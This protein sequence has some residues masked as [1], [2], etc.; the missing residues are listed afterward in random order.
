MFGIRIVTNWC[1]AWPGIKHITIYLQ[2]KHMNH[3][4]NVAADNQRWHKTIFNLMTLM[5]Q[6]M[7]WCD[8]LRC[9]VIKH[10]WRKTDTKSARWTL[11]PLPCLISNN[12][13]HKDSYLQPQV[14]TCLLVF[15]LAGCCW[16]L[17]AVGALPLAPWLPADGALAEDRN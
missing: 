17:L 9:Q 15:D 6:C 16:D 2:C 5:K 14:P 3:L 10:F 12:K 11:Y 1:N 7:D 4:I 13:W 8:N